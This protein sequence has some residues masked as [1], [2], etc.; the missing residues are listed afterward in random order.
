[1]YIKSL[2]AKGI[3][4][5]VMNKKVQVSILVLQD[6]VLIK[7]GFLYDNTEY[8]QFKVPV[9]V[10]YFAGKE[11][12]IVPMMVEALIIRVPAYKNE[13]GLAITEFNML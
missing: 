13:K 1:M 8:W 5:S 2:E 3:K 6:P 11:S 9:S 12:M 10:N 4:E 7:N